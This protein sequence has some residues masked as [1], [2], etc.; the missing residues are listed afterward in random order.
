[1]NNRAIGV[2]DSGLGGLTA[3]KELLASLPGEQII[4]FGDTGRVPYGTRS[5]ETVRQYVLQD[6]RFLKQFDIKMIL[7]ACGTASAIALEDARREND[8]PI[9]GVVQAAAEAAVKMTKNGRIGVLGTAATV[10]SGAYEKEIKRMLPNASVVS[11]AC[12]LFVPLVENGYLEHEATRLIA[13]DY[14]RE[15]KAAGVDTLILGCTHYPLLM[16]VIREIMGP[17]VA[18]VNSGAE[19]AH[20]VQRYLSENGLL[21]ERGTL[22]APQFYVSDS[23]EQFSQLGSLFLAQTLEAKAEKI[24]IETY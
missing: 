20:G 2:F 17:C 10:Q 4:Y 15:Q 11:T 6:I 24:M 16:G 22:P 13:A 19:A 12:G 21:A 18:L 3:V 14:L 23:A 8:L 1:M 7:L 5:H 9:L